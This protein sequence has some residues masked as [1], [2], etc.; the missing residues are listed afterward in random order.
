MS[1]NAFTGS[2]SARFDQLQ[3]YW[4]VFEPIS[5]PNNSVLYNLYS[6]PLGQ[7]KAPTLTI[8]SGSVSSTTGSINIEKEIH[9]F[10]D[11]TEAFRFLTDL[12]PENIAS[13]SEVEVQDG[14]LGTTKLIEVHVI[15]YPSIE[16]DLNLLDTNSSK[17]FIVEPFLSGS[18]L[19][20]SGSRVDLEPVTKKIRFD[21]FQRV[22]SDTYLRYFYIG[23]DETK[24]KSLENLLKNGDKIQTPN[25]KPDSEDDI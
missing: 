7:T 5:D 8:D 6:V 22:I 4:L 10:A 21:K 14:I 13:Y 16:L 3:D 23:T 25:L 19:D 15:N 11:E 2:E 17:G 18:P 1:N 9:I 20:V 24:D 12:G